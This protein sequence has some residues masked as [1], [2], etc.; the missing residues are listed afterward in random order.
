MRLGADPKTFFSKTMFTYAHRKSVEAVADGLV[1]GARVDGYI[2]DQLN[3]FYPE[4]IAKT[5]LVEKSEKYGFPPM[6][7]RADLPEADFRKLR[8]TLLNMQNDAEGRALLA[9]MGLDKFIAGDDKLFDG[10]TAL[11]KE[12]EGAGGKRVKKF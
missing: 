9:A 8:D 7:A 3:K 4:L 11:I 1:D 2:Y 10:V 6:V 5:R 12:V